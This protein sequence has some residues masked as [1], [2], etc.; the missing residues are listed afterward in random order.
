MRLQMFTL[1]TQKPPAPDPSIHHH[2]TIM[3]HAS[4]PI[5][6]SLQEKDGDYPA[7]AMGGDPLLNVPFSI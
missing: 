3:K 5:P 2:E 4:H 7:A 1:I 6:S